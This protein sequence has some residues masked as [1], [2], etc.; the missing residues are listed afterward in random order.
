V[1]SLVTAAFAA[2]DTAT[3]GARSVL[4]S[5]SGSEKVKH[6]RGEAESESTL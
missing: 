1:F 3:N 2:P 6:A 5:A 4:E